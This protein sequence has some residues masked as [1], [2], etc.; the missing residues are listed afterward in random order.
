MDDGLLE[1][2]G[3]LEEAGFAE[4]WD[5]FPKLEKFHFPD[6]SCSRVISGRSSVR[7]V[8]CRV[9]E[10]TSGIISTPTFRSLARTKA[11][12]L[13][14]GSSAIE[15]FSAET[16]PDKI[17]RLRFPTLTSRPSAVESSDSSLGRKLFTLTR[18]GRVITAKSITATTIPKIFSARFMAETPSRI[19]IFR[20]AV[21]S[22]R[23]VGNYSLLEIG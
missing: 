9:L 20:W 12:L 21:S 19:L 18:K 4:A 6:A 13:N 7:S 15:R 5:L 2:D 14:A 8:T 17:E 3:S 10:K 23:A 11:S 1:E 16:L 22:E